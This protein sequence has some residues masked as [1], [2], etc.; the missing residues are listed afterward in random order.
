MESTDEK[1]AGNEKKEE[2]A[3]HIGEIL[4]PFSSRNTEEGMDKLNIKGQAEDK[5]K[6]CSSVH[7]E[8][9]CS[10]WNHGNEGNIGI[11]EGA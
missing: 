8:S 4:K 7:P 1:V 3:A 2:Q 9:Q 11:D 6:V 5:E 10:V